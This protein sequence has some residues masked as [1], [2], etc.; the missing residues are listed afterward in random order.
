MTTAVGSHA[1][2]ARRLGRVARRSGAPAG[3]GRLNRFRV[4]HNI[5]P[6]QSGVARRL[7]RAC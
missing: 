3:R 4:N 6:A 7:A 2:A 1:V 5:A